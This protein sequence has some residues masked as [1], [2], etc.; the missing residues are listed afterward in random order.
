LAL[1]A[2]R[3]RERRVRSRGLSSQ[4]GMERR[5]SILSVAIRR[6]LMVHG[7]GERLSTPCS[8]A[9]YPVCACCSLKRTVASLAT[10]LTKHTPCLLWRGYKVCIRR[11][12][13]SQLLQTYTSLDNIHPCFLIAQHVAHGESVW[14]SVSGRNGD[15]LSA[16]RGGMPL[17]PVQKQRCAGEY[18][19]R[20]LHRLVRHCGLAFFDRWAG[21]Q[22]TGV[23]CPYG[24]VWH[25]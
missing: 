17:C 7:A 24:P 21:M 25:D 15:T 11:R 4:R 2:C 14:D 10:L 9:L 6:P 3:R 1:Q 12:S 18:P 19:D 5:W 22:Q 23:C 13:S 16:Q 8:P 20:F